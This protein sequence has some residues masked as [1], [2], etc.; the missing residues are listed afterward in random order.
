M[1][2]PRGRPIHENLSTSYV[3]LAALLAELQI[4]EFTGYV[5]MNFWN[6]EGYVFLDNGQLINAYERAETVIKR[7]REAVDSI[8]S[9]S[10]AR[11]GAIS[12]FHHPEPVIRALAGIINGEVVYREL[13]SEFT[14]LERLVDKL[15]KTPEVIWYV[16]VLLDREAGA[17]VIYIIDGKA[18]A[19]VS[20]RENAES[21]VLR[22][23]T[24]S[25]G[26]A[27]LV[28]QVN[29]VG[30]VFHV[31]R[32]A[33]TASA[34]SSPATGYHQPVP[35]L[36][37]GSSS[38]SN[39]LLPGV[40]TANVTAIS[41]VRATSSRAEMEPATDSLVVALED[42]DV[43]PSAVEEVHGSPVSLTTEQYSELVGLMGDVMA[44]V[45][46]GIVDIVR[47]PDF[48][49]AFREAAIR[50][51]EHYPFLDPF[52]GEFE[53]TAGEIV[54][55]G[56]ARPVDF[57]VG[58]SQ[59]LRWTLDDL[60]RRFTDVDLEARVEAT[61]KNLQ[62]NRRE[63]FEKFGLESAIEAILGH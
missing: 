15:K 45:E 7:G 13:A 40:S 58:L 39:P 53:Y 10:Q 54:F 46:R 30:G 25:E 27:V 49:L 32:D 5:S 60:S 33:G 47:E 44:A 16:E 34:P 2:V 56:S 38:T 23:A 21:N 35:Q 9:R 41:S 57:V 55:L 11:G 51:A 42:D 6:Y 3:N 31:Y 52:A 1:H 14:H 62:R 20:I 19:V 22:T 61:L 12:F 28:A 8:L 26:L 24:G 63:D 37:A 17:G 48:R 50:A 43:D 4:S 59:S 36:T 18:E 29:S